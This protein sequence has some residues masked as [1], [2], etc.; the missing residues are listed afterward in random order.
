MHRPGQPRQI[1]FTLIEL[2][3]V[4]VVAGLLLVPLLRMAGSAVVST[5]LKKTQSV[6][7]TASGALIAFAAANG[8]CMPFA[9]DSEGGLPDTDAA[10][11][12]SASPD[13]GQ[14]VIGRHAGDLPWADLGLTNS[15]LDGDGLRIQYYVATPYTDSNAT[16]PVLQC[17]AGFRGFPYDMNVEYQAPASAPL[18]VYA[19]PNAGVRTL[20]E[21]PVGYTLFVAG[22]PSDDAP[23]AD[24]NVMP[25]PDPLPNPLLQLLKGPDI[26]SAT[27]G[28]NNPFDDDIENLQNV[29]VLIA[30]GPNRNA[31]I[32]RR[33]S[34]DSAHKASAA[35]V[36]WALGTLDVD[37]IVFSSEP[38]A[39]AADTANSGDDTLL[40]MTFEDFK[41][42]M[43]KQGL[44]MEPVCE[45]INSC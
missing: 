39:D 30:P 31:G 19:T 13:T 11:A 12:A 41:K 21:I 37:G 25:H 3:I 26:S 44:N 43:S 17:D 9:A 18:W 40:N 34:R 14:G 5:R 6:L 45:N 33:F 42:E 28:Q 7:E 22:T 23:E 16:S 1:G 24:V 27:D 15:F 20:Y 4:M 38:N 2:T 8:G 10:G 29:F 32:D 36:T 35:G